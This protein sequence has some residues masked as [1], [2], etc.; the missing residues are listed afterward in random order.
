MALSQGQL[1]TDIQRFLCSGD[2]KRFRL[3]IKT[4]NETG[5]FNKNFKGQ[6]LKNMSLF[7]FLY[8]T[9]F[10]SQKEEYK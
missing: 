10:C 3:T 6:H 4:S 8:L 7:S 9:H 5:S 2:N 1:T